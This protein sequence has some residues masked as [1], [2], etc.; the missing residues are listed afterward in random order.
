MEALEQQQ[1]REPEEWLE[2]AACR[3]ANPDLFFSEQL[4]EIAQAKAACAG[5]DVRAQC[6]DSALRRREPWGIW[7]G[8]LFQAGKVLAVKRR[9]GRPR[10]TQCDEQ[11]VQVA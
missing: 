1:F 3:D 11:T 10:K 5:C 2:Q 8:E 6:L 9:R 7:G 4:D